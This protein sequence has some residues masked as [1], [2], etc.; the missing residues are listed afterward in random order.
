[1]TKTDTHY[2]AIGNL[3]I[4]KEIG[5][6]MFPDLAQ[7]GSSKIAHCIVEQDTFSGDLGRKL[8]PSP[9]ET[10][11]LLATPPFPFTVGSNGVQGGNDGICMLI[12]SP[13]SLSTK[14]L[15]IFGDSFFR[16]MLPMLAVFY[17]SIVFCRTR[18]FHYE[19]I[20]AVN[21]DHVL[22]GI[23]ER[24]LSQCLADAKRPHFLSYPYLTGRPT[25]PDPAF[26][27]L[28]SEE[29]DQRKLLSGTQQPRPKSVRSSHD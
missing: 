16:A 23:A 5:A 29:I 2:S 6:A 8:S 12:R 10:T 26:S 24:Y 9:T 11:W 3:A 27:A 13:Q 18:F 19:L 21:P 17:R 25:S 28:W 1:V 20:E 4:T 15:L 14:K 7:V 22:C